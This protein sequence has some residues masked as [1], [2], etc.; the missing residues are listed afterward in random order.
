MLER[1][2]DDE[3]LGMDFDEVLVELAE[4]GIVPTAVEEPEADYL[5]GITVGSIYLDYYEIEFDEDGVCDSCYHG[6]CEE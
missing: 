6:S 2:H 1:L 3:F 4:R 5:G